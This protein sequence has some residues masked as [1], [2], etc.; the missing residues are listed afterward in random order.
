MAVIGTVTPGDHISNSGSRPG[1]RLILTKPLGTGIITTAGKNAAV[2]QKL[3]DESIDVMS[4]LNDTASRLMVSI[5]VNAATD[6][7]GFGLIGHLK[8]MMIQ[9]KVSARIM[10]SSIPIIDGVLELIDRG[11]VPGGT[12]RNLEDSTE[13]V[14]W[15]NDLSLREKLLLSDSQTSGGLLISVPNHMNQPDLLLLEHSVFVLTV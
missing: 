12:S 13:N 9:S 15:S 11:F 4:T 5:G 7:T 10:T 8:N 14:E 3:L 1:D 2:S 6:V